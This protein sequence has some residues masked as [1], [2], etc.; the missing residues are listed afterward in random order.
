MYFP[1]YYTRRLQLTDGKFGNQTTISFWKKIK[2][3]NFVYIPV[4]ISLDC[5]N[6]AYISFLLYK[7]FC[8][9]HTEAA[10]SGLWEKPKPNVYLPKMVPLKKISRGVW[11]IRV[12]RELWGV[13]GVLWKWKDTPM[14]PYPPLRLY[15]LSMVLCTLVLEAHWGGGEDVLLVPWWCNVVY[16]IPYVGKLIFPHI[17]ILG[18]AI[19]LN[20]HCFLIVLVTP[21]D[22]LSTMVK[23]SRVDTVLRHGCDDV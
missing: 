19:N 3:T 11:D 4:E 23:H 16:L 8:C 7:L 22:S 18:W 1:S 9:F 2:V 20:V 21:Y 6:K 15:I 10:S 17:P 5:W 14:G 13:R 12:Y